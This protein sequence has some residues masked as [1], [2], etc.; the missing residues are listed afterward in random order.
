MTIEDPSLIVRHT[1]D[2]AALVAAHPP[3]FTHKHKQLVYALSSPPSRP[4]QG[5][6][7]FSRHHAMPLGD[8][9]PAA[10]PTVEMREDVFGYEPLPKS[11]PPT[12]E[13]YLNFADPQ[14][15]VAYGGS[16]LAQDELQVLEHPALGSL[17]EHLRASPDPRFAPLTH[18]GDAATPVLVRGVERRCAFATDPDLLEGRPLGLY[19]N[20]FARASEDAIR[21]AVTV[22]DPPTLSN[23]LAMAAPPGGTGAYSIDEI[24]SILT[25]ATTGF[26]AARIESDLAAK[27]AAVVIHTGHWGTGAFGGNKVL[28]TILQLLAARLARIDRLVYHT[29]DST[30]SDAFQEGA[31]RLAKLLPDGASMPVADMIQKLFR[32]GFVWGESDGN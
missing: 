18:D 32:I 25:T 17:C 29:F 9:L 16:L 4:P 12:V 3:R 20:R 6:L 28:M 23:I 5:A 24:R 1:F 19:G 7:V 22:L 8:H 21:R 31:K 2:A 11:S 10:A 15:F 27:G 13:W 30:G 26:S 14:L